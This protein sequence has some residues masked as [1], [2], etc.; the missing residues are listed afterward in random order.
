MDATSR[1]FIGVRGLWL[2]TPD[3]VASRSFYTGLVPAGSPNDSPCEFIASEGPSSWLV[4]F[5]V[6]DADEAA[7]ECLRRGA[8]LSS[9]TP[10]AAVTEMLDPRGVRFALESTGQG[11]SAPPRPGTAVLA[12][13]YTRD[14]AKG[15][16]FYAKA[17][18]LAVDVMPD[19]P[20][21]YVKLSSDAGHVLG[22]LD[23]TSF[24]DPSAPD[25]W[26]PYLYAPDIELAISRATSLGAWVVA[27]A[28]D[29]PTGRYAILKDPLGCLF[30]FWD[31]ESLSQAAAT[32]RSGRS[33][34]A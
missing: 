27:P 18:H 32:A 6:S 10:A 23:M 30:G 17:F 34:N 16:D 33:A 3:L 1:H 2:R 4:S 5:G 20:V 9:S 22:I 12:D 31:A 19:D 28:S 7:A 24:L 29:S 11:R 26:M 14:V 15:E 8:T 21:D 25:H 13:L